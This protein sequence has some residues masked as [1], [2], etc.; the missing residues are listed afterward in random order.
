MQAA[1]SSISAAVEQHVRSHDVGFPA[2][3]YLSVR[4]EMDE[5]PVSYEALDLPLTG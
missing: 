1:T 3:D 2:E 5:G 4:L